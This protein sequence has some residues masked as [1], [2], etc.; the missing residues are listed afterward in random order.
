MCL[1]QS[2]LRYSPAFE[3]FFCLQICL[4]ACKFCFAEDAYLSCK[5][6][7]F[8]CF[9]DE[10]TLCKY[11]SMP[12]LFCSAV[13]D[14][15]IIAQRSVSPCLFLVKK[16]KLYEFCCS[17]QSAVSNKRFYHCALVLMCAWQWCLFIDF[18]SCNVFTLNS[19]IHLSEKRV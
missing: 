11:C 4:C 17:W 16:K 7:R 18:I 6:W 1:F 8:K 9:C 5:S 19:F 14:A 2:N 13:S 3:W 12:W 15:K 10:K